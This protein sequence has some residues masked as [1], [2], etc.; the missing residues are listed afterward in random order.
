MAV[1]TEHSDGN[2][3]LDSSLPSRFPI[4]RKREKERNSFFFFSYLITNG[5]FKFVYIIIEVFWVLQ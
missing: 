3:K 5:V 1:T 2:I 4:Y